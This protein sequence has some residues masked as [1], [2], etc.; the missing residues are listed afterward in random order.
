VLRNLI[1]ADDNHIVVSAEMMLL[2]GL[3]TSRLGQAARDFRD[4]RRGLRLPVA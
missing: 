1:L 3:D 4:R 2:D